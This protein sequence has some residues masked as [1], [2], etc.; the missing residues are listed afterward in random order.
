[1]NSILS[2]V[3]IKGNKYLN[4]FFFIP[5]TEYQCPPKFIIILVRL[6]NFQKD[7]KHK[8]YYIVTAYPVLLCFAD[9]FQGKK[10]N[11]RFVAIAM[12]RF[13]GTIFPA[14]F[15]HFMRLPFW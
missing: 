12:N 11:K 2:L 14:A 5:I 13:I 1:M 6:S 10:I 8:N 9:A 15:G 7:L 4:L 3:P